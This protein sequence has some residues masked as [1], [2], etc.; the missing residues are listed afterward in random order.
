MPELQIGSVFAGHRI[1]AVAGRGGMG[2]LYR[3][4]HLALEREVALKVIAADLA[5]SEDFR[6]RFKRES[7]TAA[8]IQHPNVIPIFHAGE[9]DG[10]LYITM[11]FIEGTDLRQTISAYGALPPGD[12][13]ELTAQ[14]A[15]GLDAA[16]KRG[17]VHRDVKP[18]NILIANEGGRNRAY[19]TDFGL[20][21]QASS[22]EGL[23]KTGMYVGT[24][25]YIS[26]EQLRGTG[27]DARADVYALGCVLYQALTG[28]VP[29]P[30]DSEP[31]KMWAHMGEDPPVVTPGPPERPR[32]RSTRSSGAPWPR[33]PATGTRPP[34]TSDAPPRPPPRTSA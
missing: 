31:A 14:V 13:A 33:S 5:D 16:H 30:R 8:S 29:Y 27:V 3:A 15:A 10:V 25:D 6:E 19:L 22:A 26:P 12:A 9:E 23:T 7:R 11:R 20:T 21:K 24:L 34:A 1:D 18:A 28:A 32:R 2:V 17:L 4:T